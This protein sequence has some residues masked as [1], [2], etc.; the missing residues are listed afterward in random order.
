MK[1]KEVWV[2]CRTSAR[3]TA[4]QVLFSSRL[5][6]SHSNTHP[7]IDS[8]SDTPSQRIPLL[9]M[10]AWWRSVCGGE[11]APNDLALLS[12][13]ARGAPC[14]RPKAFA[15]INPLLICSRLHGDWPRKVKRMNWFPLSFL[16]VIIIIFFF[17]PACALRSPATRSATPAP[18]WL[19][20]RWTTAL[21]PRPTATTW[22]RSR[23]SAPTGWTRG[24]ATRD[25]RWAVTLGCDPVDGTRCRGG[26][27]C[28][29][30]QRRSLRD[31][32]CD[33]IEGMSGKVCKAGA[34]KR[35]RGG[36]FWCVGSSP[37]GRRRPLGAKWKLLTA[38]Q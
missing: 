36:F 7:G 8:E 37:E 30:R 33:I 31:T 12:E 16:I 10:Y 28:T 2:I 26:T 4:T 27:R 25:T 6:W 34:G 20:T 14:L 29:R 5:H 1:N 35:S 15:N 32:L 17:H 21:W 13:I 24:G 18:A 11:R 19:S 22:P 9:N 38:Q 3:E 23:R